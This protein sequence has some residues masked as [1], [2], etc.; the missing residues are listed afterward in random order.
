MHTCTLYIPLFPEK[1]NLYDTLIILEH[2]DTACG[3]SLNVHLLRA[4]T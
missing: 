2:W 4:D 3:L 1:K